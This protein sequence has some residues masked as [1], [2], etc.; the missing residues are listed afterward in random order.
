MTHDNKD[1]VPFEK[2][3]ERLDIR[4][5]FEKK[6][7]FTEACENQGDTPS[8]AVR[9]FISTYI[10]REQRDEVAAAIR[11]SP[12]KRYL[13]YFALGT[14]L[15]L[16]AGGIL[17]AIETQK[18]TA[19]TLELFAAYDKNKNNFIDLGEISSNDYHLQRVL[20]IDGVDGISPSEFMLEGRM[21]WQFVNPETFEIVKH[22]QGTFKQTSKTRMVT[23]GNQSF[24]EKKK[25]TTKMVEFDLRNPDRINI[26][27]L[28][29]QAGGTAVQT[30]TNYQRSVDW[31]EGQP[32]PEIVMGLGHKKAV[33]TK[34]E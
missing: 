24:A 2:K 21:N 17:S 13:G 15:V 23:I 34:S 8:N 11:F 3:T 1:T 9:R 29:Q 19:R 33:L 14:I 5:S 6:K 20:N 4:V 32:A 18:Q 31:I 25:Y 27:V 26:T 16:S 28:E 12:W 30:F 7:A 22:S 10:R